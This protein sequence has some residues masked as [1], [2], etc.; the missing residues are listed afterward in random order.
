MFSL[1]MNYNFLPS[2]NAKLGS[3]GPNELSNVVFL[4]NI[5]INMGIFWCNTILHCVM[6]LQLGIK[7]I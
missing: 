3:E 2:I 5:F 6:Q 4:S 1:E 7:S